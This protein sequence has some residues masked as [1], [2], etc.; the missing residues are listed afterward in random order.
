MSKD[1]WGLILKCCDQDCWTTPSPTPGAG[2]Q[3]VLDRSERNAGAARPC[4]LN[5]VGGIGYDITLFECRSLQ[6]I[7]LIDIDE[8]LFYE[9]SLRGRSVLDT[10]SAIRV[11]RR[12]SSSSSTLLGRGYE[13]A[14]VDVS[15]FR[16]LRRPGSLEKRPRR[17]VRQGVVSLGTPK[18]RAFAIR[19]VVQ[20]HLGANAH[21]EEPIQAPR[22]SVNQQP[23]SGPSNSWPSQGHNG[24]GAKFS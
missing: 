14:L 8:R 15:C 21:P 5:R 4:S 1:Y 19:L 3:G 12:L 22:V 9:A 11:L 16:I 10:P 6:G 2:T 20:Q 24:T 18:V 7:H 13:Y 17:M 23:D